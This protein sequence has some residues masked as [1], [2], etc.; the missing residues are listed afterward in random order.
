[1]D[2]ENPEKNTEQNLEEQQPATEVAGV[3]QNQEAV[4]EENNQQEVGDLENKTEVDPTDGENEPPKESESPRP[5]ISA[6]KKPSEEL[7]PVK[8]PP[9]TIK[10]LCKLP[11]PVQID[12][13]EIPL[14]WDMFQFHNIVNKVQDLLLQLDGELAGICIRHAVPLMLPSP[15]CEIRSHD[16][17]REDCTKKK[18]DTDEACRCYLE[19]K[20][21]EEEDVEK[22]IEFYAKLK[23]KTSEEKLDE[24]TKFLKRDDQFAKEVEE[25]EDASTKPAGKT[26]KGSKK[27]KEKNGEKD[28][29]SSEKRDTGGSLS[30]DRNSSIKEEVKKSVS[31]NPQETTDNIIE[32]VTEGEQNKENENQGEAKP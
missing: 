2:T 23:P 19:S 7:P 1:M 6:E 30:K 3:V 8:P 12:V 27:S 20:K 28:P 4:S 18:D 24:E 22:I 13:E 16:D 25:S 9:P 11:E 15:L 5:S 10:E 31:E 26:K 21:T 32:N 17:C 14:D 29:K